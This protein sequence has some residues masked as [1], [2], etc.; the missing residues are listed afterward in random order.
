MINNK[1]LKHLIESPLV[2]YVYQRG[3]Y[4]YG[5]NNKESDMD[6]LVIIDAQYQVPKEFRKYKVGTP[7]NK[8][9]YRIEMDGCDF[10]FYEMQDW[11]QHVLDCSLDAWEC[12][13]LDKKFIYKEHVK[14]MMTADFYKLREWF[15]ASYKANIERYKF[16]VLNNR[17]KEARKVLWYIIKDVILINQILVNH[18]IVNFKAANGAYNI[19][20]NTKENPF[21]VFEV[22]F[23]EPFKY[24]KSATNGIKKQK[25]LTK[26]IETFKDE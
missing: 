12:A 22:Q 10:L 17:E 20:M 3:S 1:Y 13:C 4:I 18:K 11:F 8:V 15:D 16:L 21:E 25:K 14:L 6:F 7:Y 5:V 24:L 19:L 26:F 2:Y 9:K 23:Q